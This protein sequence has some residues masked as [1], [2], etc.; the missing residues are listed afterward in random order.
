MMPAFFMGPDG[1]MFP[2]R[3]RPLR[4]MLRYGGPMYPGR[5]RAAASNGA[6]RAAGGHDLPGHRDELGTLGPGPPGTTT[7]SSGGRTQNE[8]F[9]SEADAPDGIFCKETAASSASWTQGRRTGGRA[10]ASGRPRTSYDSA[11]ASTSSGTGPN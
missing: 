6:R 4:A 3:P 5:L 9:V 7:A 1:R 8:V 2:C 11:E 10:R